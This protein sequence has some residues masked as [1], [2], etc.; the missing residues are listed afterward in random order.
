MEKERAT[1]LEPATSIMEGDRSDGL[2]HRATTPLARRTRRGLA[3]YRSLV[4]G[5]GGELTVQSRLDEGACFRFVLPLPRASSAP[6]DQ[7]RGGRAELR[8]FPPRKQ[9][10]R[11]P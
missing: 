4:R 8:N 1:G 7:G 3:N 2:E 6:T 10:A 11:S 9:M 5:M